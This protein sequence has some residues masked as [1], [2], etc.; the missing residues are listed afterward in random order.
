[1]I[2]QNILIFMGNSSV[3]TL[4]KKMILFIALDIQSIHYLELK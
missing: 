2:D 1:M 3:S 4:G